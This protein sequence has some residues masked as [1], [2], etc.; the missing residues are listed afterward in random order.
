MWLP[1]VSLF[2]ICLL[3]ESSKFRVW[4]FCEFDL[5]SGLN[6][7]PRGGDEK[8]TNLIPMPTDASTCP[9]WEWPLKT[10]SPPELTP[11][12]CWGWHFPKPGQKVQCK[13]RI[14]SALPICCLQGLTAPNRA[15]QESRPK[16]A[17]LIWPQAR[18]PPNPY[19]TASRRL[20]HSS[21]SP[22]LTQAQ[23][24][25]S[26]SWQFMLSNQ[27]RT[28]WG[29]EATLTFSRQQHWAARTHTEVLA[30][31]QAH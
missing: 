31:C 4:C 11:S 27:I 28:P 17:L 2:L 1:L 16:R 3:L 15:P 8:H 25:L 21:E 5:A 20:T 19:I 18:N 22:C 6:A 10:A 13:K 12:V 23:E 7:R 14:V 24:L 9:C 30:S 26:R 29:A